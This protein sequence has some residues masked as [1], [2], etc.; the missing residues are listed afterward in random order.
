[1]LDNTRVS[2]HNTMTGYVYIY[3]CV[4]GNHDIVSNS[5]AAQ[6]SRIDANVNA[7]ADCGSARSFASGETNSSAFQNVYIITDY[8]VGRN[9]D[10]VGM[11]HY[12]PPA[13]L[14]GGFDLDTIFSA[15]SV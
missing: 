6:N 5:N 8:G 10:I 3:K 4:G 11:G 13:N 9:G 7:V 2:N 15:Q 14:C 1:M 12:K